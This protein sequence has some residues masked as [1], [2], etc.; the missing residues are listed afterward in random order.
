MGWFSGKDSQAAGPSAVR[1]S[2]DKAAH[3]A[4]SIRASR[5]GRGHVS[6]IKATTA[7]THRPS[8]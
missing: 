2:K 8:W 1:A 3:T 4:K 7:P 6:P 5:G